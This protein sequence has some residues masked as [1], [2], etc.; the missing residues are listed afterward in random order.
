MGRTDLW[1]GLKDME[2]EGAEISGD[3]PSRTLKSKAGREITFR[4]RVATTINHDP[5]DADGYPTTPWIRPSWF[6]VDGPSFLVTVAERDDAPIA[7]KWSDWPAG[8]RYASN[9]DHMGT[10]NRRHSVFIGGRDLRIVQNGP[11]RLA[12]RGQYPFTD[13]ELAVDLARILKA[14]RDFFADEA[15]APY[16]VAAS[17]LETGPRQ[18]FRGTWKDGAF[19]MVASASM[20]REDLRPFL[21]HE[22]FHAWNPARL[23]VPVGP[24][25][26]WFSE[27][28]TDFYA[29]RLLQRA[30]LL[31]PTAFADAWNETL[32]GYGVSPAKTMPGAQ[33]AE[34][35]WT[36]PDAE[37]IAYQRGA[38]LA[39]LWDWRLRQRGQSLDA[40]VR[41]QAQAFRKNPDA[42][43]TDLFVAAMARAGID[44][45]EDLVTYI[46]KGAA[47]ALP[48]D[49][50]SPCGEL[51]TV[52]APGFDLGFEPVAT[53]D[54]HLRIA[55]V[56]PGGAAYRAGLRDG[57][58]IVR[59]VSGTSGD[60]TRPYDL[61]I[62]LPTGSTR[63]IRYLPQG[64]GTVR[65][66]RLILDP[67]AVDHAKA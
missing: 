20:T 31:S 47:I 46:D 39:V 56:K 59:K 3:G 25:G 49:A 62:R 2:A 21:A 36:D 44:V 38:M 12:I 11:V 57:M 53:R 52:T 6:F 64:L 33:A 61:L 65:Y 27:G 10:K 1:R 4:Y 17:S 42:A 29:R 22:L 50:F 54:G 67:A 37:K 41:A 55:H 23:G 32:R 9:L 66:Q 63:A 60:A 14:E 28:L 15:D 26:Y 40:V 35:F 45:G 30:R 58:T 34:A 18:S 7:L 48:A 51:E 24:K 8:F 19:A 43:V 16:L 13:A 5:T